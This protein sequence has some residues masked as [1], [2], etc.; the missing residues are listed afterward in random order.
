[1]SLLRTSTLFALAML[2]ANP[3]LAE[4]L[5]C[6]DL[7][8]LQRLAGYVTLLGFAKVLGASIFAFGLIAVAGGVI[9]K[10]VYQSRVLIEIAGYVLSF[11]LIGA[12]Y[13]MPD[14]TQ[15]TWLV[16]TGCI[17]FGGTVMM[18]LWIHEIKGDDPKPLAA[19]FMVVWGAVAVFY[20]MPEVA[21]LSVMALMT[22]LGF[23]I[24]VGRLS[25]AFG[26]EN[27]ASIPSGTT[28]ALVL[29]AVALVLHAYVPSAPDAVSVFKPGLFWVASFVGFVGLLI[30]ASRW[31]GKRETY[32]AR[33]I[34]TIVVLFG[35][36]GL[37]LVLGL[38]PLAGM[39]GVFLV[40]YLASKPIEIETHGKIAFGLTL[41]A[42]GGILYTAW[43]YGMKHQD[44]VSQYLTTQI[45]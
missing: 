45:S 30:I 23:S 17:L 18:T 39:A 7:T 2:M 25:Y 38:N 10:V 36:V 44:V 11:V 32:V 24:I 19:L 5:T 8:T 34:V 3:A 37:G 41:M 42:T 15:L 1:M 20:N 16:L 4:T 43:W 26:F 31:Y 14:T 29:L 22:L 6:P 13:F 35:S 21:A 9:V 40:L 27:D 33:Q 28:A 12:G